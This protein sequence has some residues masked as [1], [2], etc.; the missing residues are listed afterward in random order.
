MILSKKKKLKL[1]NYRYK[2]ITMF[3]KI[4]D[5][6]LLN[7]FINKYKMMLAFLKEVRMISKRNHNYKEVSENQ[8]EINHKLIK[9][10][11]KRT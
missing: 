6:N 10:L 7:H 2:L 5:N 8:K 1:K 11:I 4:A 3:V 9:L